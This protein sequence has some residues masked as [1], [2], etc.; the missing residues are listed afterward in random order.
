MVAS[1]C[2]HGTVRQ[3]V[4]S[5]QTMSS[6]CTPRMFSSEHEQVFFLSKYWLSRLQLLAKHLRQQ[7][8]QSDA[9]ALLLRDLKVVL[10]LLNEVHANLQRYLID[11]VD[12]CQNTERQDQATRP[13]SSVHLCLERLYVNNKLTTLLSDNSL[14]AL[15]P[16][17]HWF[18]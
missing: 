1:A 2:P 3:L 8:A 9:K 15:P 13:T 16:G 5:V 11:Y 10:K 7:T 12:D 6:Q 4:L 18:T 14:S 17:K